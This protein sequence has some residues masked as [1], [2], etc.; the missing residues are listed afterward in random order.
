MNIRKHGISFLIWL[1][2]AMAA[3]AVVYPR[4]QVD[5]RRQAR[6]TQQ[7]KGKKAGR[8]DNK[9][10]AKTN[11]AN[12]NDLIIDDDSIPDSLLNPRWKIQ[13]T[14]PITY[15]DLD[16]GV[17]DL[18]RPEGLRYEVIYN[19]SLDRYIIGA[20]FGGSYLSTP[21]MMTTDEYLK[22]SEKH[23]RDAYFRSKNDEIYEAKGKEKFDFA[24][25]H[26]DLGPAEKIFGPGGVRIR[27]QGTAEL[28]FGATNKKIDNPSLPV[29]NRN[30]TTMDFD[31]KINLNVNG[32]VGD[33]VNMNLNYNTDA[34]FDFDSQNM[35][36]KY[37]GKEDEIVKLVEGGNISFPSN[38]S[39]VQGASSLFGLRTD[40]QFG[41]LKLQ[42]VASQKKSSS[43]SVSSKGGTQLT[44]FEI[45]AANYEENRHFFLS[46]YFRSHYDAA[47]KTLPNLTTGVTIN[48]V[49]IWVTNKTGTTTNTRN[50]V[51]LT[52]LGENTSVSNPMWSAGGSPVPANGANTE[53]ATV[54]G[55][56]ADARNID[57]TSTVLDG[58]GLVGGSDYE[59]LQSARLLNSSEYSVNTALGYVSLRTSLQTDQVLAIAYEYTYGGQ[60]Y[61]VGEFASDVTDVNKERVLP[62]LV[63]GAREVP[64]RRQVPKRHHGCVPFLYTRTAG[65]GPNAH[66]APGGRPPRQQQQGA[67][68]RLLRLRGGLHREQ[69]PCVLPRGRTVW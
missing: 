10:N 54:V 50:I 30:K 55:Q 33:K 61:Q 58:A 25:M 56:L 42:L 43:K 49:E 62:G 66:Q 11:G 40:L 68:Q 20:K 14:T 26:F 2:I 27:T 29:R 16:Q 4:Q 52:D 6:R 23:A 31:E 35:K 60:T 45:D 59:K 8:Q 1:A 64:S 48:R 34:T 28:K 32:K 65:K 5:P 21:F 46:Q 24:D 17:L 36:L 53:Y 22:W 15:G 37:D 9:K 63:G 19:D 18:Q 51:A 12:L 13:R 67:P 44:P 41:K 7:D 3:Y 39:L 57:Q 38:S 69:R 47:M